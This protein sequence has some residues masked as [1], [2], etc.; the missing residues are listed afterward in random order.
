[1]KIK[2]SVRIPIGF[3]AG[4][5]FLIRAEPVLWSFVTG[6]AFM[7]CGEAVRFVS[8]GTLIKYEGVTRNGIYA[9][10]RNPL[11]FGSF[12]IGVGACIM[13]RDP[14]FA[15]FFFLVFPVVY[16]RIIK[17][18]EAFLRGRYGGEYERYSREVP[19]F[20]SFRLD[21]GDALRESS[22]FLAV[23]NGELRAV[24]G[25]VLVVVVMVVKMVVKK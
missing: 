16:L 25:V 24:A 21:V 15:L 14:Y 17:D 10:T 18:E 23:K 19:R 7:I 22:L 3:A 9:C 4:A 20:W 8:A 6:L 13:G 1:M 2:N 12:L 5:A 11:Y